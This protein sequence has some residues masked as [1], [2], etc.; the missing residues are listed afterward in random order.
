MNSQ[1]LSRLSRIQRN[2]SMEN[3]VED[4]IWQLRIYSIWRMNSQISL[5]DSIEFSEKK[6]GIGVKI[7]YG[8]FGY[9]PLVAWM[10]RIYFLFF[11]KIHWSN[12]KLG[13]RWHVRTYGISYLRAE[14]SKFT[15][16]FLEFIG[17][18]Y[19]IGLKIGFGNLGSISLE[20]QILRIYSAFLEFT[21]NINFF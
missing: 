8:N 5:R 6:K 3:R 13:C 19:K 18:K 9:H 2:K 21:K 16:F 11:S 10:L 1:N 7:A 17:K 14:F 4:W 12:G 15:P 20:G